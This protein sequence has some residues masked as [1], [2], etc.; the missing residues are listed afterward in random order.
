MSTAIQLLSQP[1]LGLVREVRKPQVMMAASVQDALDNGGVYICEGPVGSGKTYAY[2]V[3]TILATNRRFV[4]A[5]AKKALQDQINLK[6]VPAIAS[7]I[8][9]SVLR[10]ACMN[11]EGHEQHLA[12]VVKGKS[13][14]ACRLLAQKFS[15]PDAYHEWIDKSAYGDRATY[16]GFVPKWWPN[17]T[18][19]GCI[20]RGCKSYRSCGY[21]RLRQEMLLSR[22]LVINHHLLGSDM[23]YGHGKMV[24]GPFSVLVIDEAHKLADGIRSAFTL[25]VAEGS[26]DDLAQSLE[27]SSFQFMMPRKISRPW[28]Q[29]FQSLPNRH[30]RDAHEREPP[31][32]DTE[33][34]SE[35]LEGLAE[36]DLELARTLGVYG[37]TGDPSDA[38]YWERF[39]A[40]TENLPDDVRNMLANIGVARRKTEH[41][42]VGLNAAQGRACDQKKDED[43]EE[44]EA[45]N[46]GRLANLVIAASADRSGRVTITGAPVDLGG[47]AKAYLGQIKTVIVTSATLAIN[48]S[49]DHLD[50]V[51]GVKPTKTEILPTTFNYAKQ[52]FFYIPRDLPYVNR[53][54]E[55]HGPALLKKAQ[56]AE[57]LIR[58]SN[59]GAFVLTTANDELDM[60]AAHLMKTLPNKI[61]VQGHSKNPWHG[62]AQTVLE[63]YM[64]TP[65]AVLVGSRSFWEGV[66][67]EGERLRLV[68]I[69]KL[70]FPMFG[71]PIIK[72]RER[73]AGENA[74]QRVQVG[75]M[76][77]DLRQGAGRLIRSSS[78]RGVVA[79]LDSRAWTKSYGRS[80]RAALG[81]PV[82]DDLGLCSRYLPQVVKYFQQRETAR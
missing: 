19:E 64:R 51:I 81:F 47:I 71:D 60:F 4:I 80:V 31:V 30:W 28:N 16:P 41:L 53:N 68:I 21:T 58:W 82:T 18:A 37:I 79:L 22:G 52:G 66:D 38:S 20:G 29:M 55:E 1:A 12:R 9:P 3:P 56:R 69:A 8:E 57:Q 77:M 50:N 72:A 39:A 44:Y 35:C 10:A 46:E 65:N 62:D 5:T 26:I 73:L 2:L 61:F 74:F 75:D 76:L 23:S 17:A 33:L 7:R 54:D 27:N 11:D 48:G 15:P 70:P 67:V 13:N 63:M 78:D 6:D 36:I 42:K 25:R 45:R 34:A 49:F 43:D 24:G 59:G 32:F 14:Y 40:Q